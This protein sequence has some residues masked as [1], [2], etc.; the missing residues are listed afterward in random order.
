ML[1]RDTERERGESSEGVET[2]QPALRWLDKEKE[3]KGE[4]GRNIRQMLA[5]NESFSESASCRGISS[6]RVRESM[7]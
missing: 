5:E 2:N 7:H 3:G 4:R 6:L 1:M